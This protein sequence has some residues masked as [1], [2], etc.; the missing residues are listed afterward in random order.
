MREYLNW[1]SAP[2]KVHWS[3][4]REQKKAQH[5][6]YKAA[7]KAAK[8]EVAKAQ[9]ACR[10]MFRERL[11]SEEGQRAVF[12]IAKQIAKERCDVMGVSC[13]KDEVGQIVVDPDGIKG[14]WKRYMEILLNAENEWDGNIE[15][16]PVFGP[17]EKITEKEVEEAIK[18]MKSRKARGPTGVVGDML[19]AAGNWGVKRM[20][21]I[22]NLA[23]KEGR[24]PVDWEQSTLVPLYKGKGD[25]LECGSYRAIKVLEHGMKV[26]ERVLERRK[27]KKVK[28]DEMQ[29]GFMPGRGTTNVIFIVMQ[30]QYKYMYK[31]KTLFWGVC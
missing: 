7:K 9:E 28:T 12:R 22:C 25:P 10:K 15:S 11:D 19:K 13:L 4:V 18:A 5:E 16:N 1:S 8:K 14:R 27:R 29:F 31:R 6:S 30:L 26:L 3:R 21:K 17:A 24:I 2:I 20:T 23:V